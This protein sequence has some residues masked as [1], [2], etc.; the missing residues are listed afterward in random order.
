MKR[1]LTFSL[2]GLI[3]TGSM[4][5]QTQAPAQAPVQ[6][7]AVLAGTLIDPETGT[8]A[9]NQVILVEGTQIRNIGANLPIPAGATVID[10]SDLN[11]LPGL[12]DA[13]VHFREP[14]VEYKEDFNTG[15]QAAV[16]G[17][18]TTVV[19]MPNVIP[20][21]AD[22][23]AFNLKVS[24]LQGKSFV[25]VAV[26]A[27]VVNTNLGQ[28]KKLWKAGV[29]GYKVFLGETVGGIPAPDDGPLIEARR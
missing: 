12:V 10:L 18:I 3:L 13:H 21:T 22:V 20:A 24:R 4:H 26:L 14:G 2:A 1:M 15:S 5:A 28:L 17:G 9:T 16:C 27:V 25:D 6:V 11:V 7:T 8:A 29:I 19:D 23:A